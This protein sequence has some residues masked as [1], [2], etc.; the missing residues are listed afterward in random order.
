VTLAG[1]CEID[2]LV[3]LTLLEHHGRLMILFENVRTLNPLK[4][5]QCALLFIYMLQLS[6]EQSVHVLDAWVMV[7]QADPDLT[8]TEVDQEEV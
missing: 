2:R 1:S 7:P 3:R 4:V 8:T 6:P 5:N